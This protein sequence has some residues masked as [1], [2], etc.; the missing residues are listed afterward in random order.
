MK[1][2]H[3]NSISSLKKFGLVEEIDGDK[4]SKETARVFSKNVK[5]EENTDP[6]NAL[7]FQ[8]KSFVDNQ[9]WA[10]RINEFPAEPLYT[11]FIND[12]PI[13]SIDGFPDTWKR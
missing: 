2:T 11:L 9:K 4:W 13:V 5:W 12:E 8:Y 3:T 7:T 10:L 1:D 6:M